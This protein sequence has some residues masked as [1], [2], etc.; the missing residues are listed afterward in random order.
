VER[1]Q[2]RKDG[3]QEKRWQLDGKG[4][5]HGQGGL[6]KMAG[7]TGFTGVE[8]FFGVE[9][10]HGQEDEEKDQKHADCDN[11]RSSLDHGL[12]QF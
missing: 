8:A 12:R 2:T 9:K 3:D 11:G 10:I 4:W 6:L 7:R 5:P 1:I